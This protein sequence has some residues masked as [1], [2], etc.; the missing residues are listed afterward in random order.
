MKMMIEISN[1]RIRKQFDVYTKKQV[2]ELKKNIRFYIENWRDN[3]SWM[4][5]TIDEMID[6]LFEG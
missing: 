4:C 6:E 1:D 2:K 3:M 5:D